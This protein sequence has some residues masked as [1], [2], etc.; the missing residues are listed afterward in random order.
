MITT[1]AIEPFIENQTNN[2]KL[3]LK[4]VDTILENNN[5]NKTTDTE[6]IL[7]TEESV[8]STEETIRENN[9]K[10]LIE[11]IK[12]ND[13]T[14]K[15]D[16]ENKEYIGPN[17]TDIKIPEITQDIANTLD[18]NN[19]ELNDLV[20]TTIKKKKKFKINN[21]NKHKYVNHLNNILNNNKRLDKLG[22]LFKND[23]LKKKIK[24][25]K[26]KMGQVQT[27]ALLKDDQNKKDFNIVLND[28]ISTFN[29]KVEK[30]NNVLENNFDQSGGDSKM[31]YYKY[32]KYK[33]KYLT[34]LL[35]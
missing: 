32:L 28:V 27:L 7:D 20:L 26:K 19:E 1:N 21:L 5:L 30:I 3:K 11:N 15:V 17:E 18:I 24:T 12:I 25:L 35:D 22:K 14:I 9:F 8:S 13:E 33:I 31:Y 6:F 2:D 23:L 16:I 34:L 10:E 29:N 4:S